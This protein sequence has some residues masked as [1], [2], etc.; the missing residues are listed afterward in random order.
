MPPQQ[1]AAHVVK[2]GHQVQPL[3]EA[4]Q[5]QRAPSSRSQ[6]RTNSHTSHANTAQGQ[7]AHGGTSSAAAE[8]SRSRPSE[9]SKPSEPYLSVTNDQLVDN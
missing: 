5:E 9:G 4:A 6:T 1:L 8:P 7:H 2:G 3:R